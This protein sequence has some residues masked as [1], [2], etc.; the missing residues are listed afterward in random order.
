MIYGE[1]ITEGRVCQ[2]VNLI[3]IIYCNGG[4]WSSN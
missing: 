3:I 1:Y 2:D 4:I